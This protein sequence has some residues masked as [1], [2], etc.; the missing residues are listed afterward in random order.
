MDNIIRD[1]DTNSLADL[2]GGAATPATGIKFGSTESTTD[3]FDSTH[4]PSLTETTTLAST[5]DTTTLAPVDDDLNQP[6]ADLL[7]DGVKQPGRPPKYDF[8][9]ISGY[10]QDRIKSGKFIAITED[11]DDGSKKPFLPKT[12]EEFDEVLDLQLSYKLE[13]EK[14]DLKSK[15]YEGMTPAWKAINQYAEMVDDPTQ[16]IPFLQGVRTIQSISAIDENDIAGAEKIVRVR[17]EQRGDPEEVISS[18]IEALK[19]T[20]KLIPTAKQYKPIIVQQEQQTLQQEFQQKKEQE[21]KYMQLVSEIRENAL[22]AIEQPIFGKKLKREEQAAIYDLIAEPSQES[23]GYGIYSAIDQLFDKGDFETLKQ[24]A[25]L[26]TKRDSFL[27]YA[28]AQGVE[29]MSQDLRKK[30]TLATESK[31]G[32]KDGS[33]DEPSV[34]RNQF[35]GSPK[36]GR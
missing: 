2:F 15:M 19:T 20:D 12:P 6:N 35:K 26:L 3:L 11:S 34:T 13:Q 10:F 4:S 23:Q 5:T 21:Q 17:M 14:K 30:L 32:G 24:V 9:D 22:K 25:L 16:L 8:S 36:F 31:G 1:L 7:G 29:K 33:T 18:Q 28:S 27:S